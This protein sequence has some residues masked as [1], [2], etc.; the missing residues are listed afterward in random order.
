MEATGSGC[1]CRQSSVP[2][3]TCTGTYDCCYTMGAGTSQTC[4]CGS[5]LTAN[6]CATSIPQIGGTV[7][8]HCRF[9]VGGSSGFE[10]HVDV[11]RGAGAGA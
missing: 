5:T 8:A 6:D 4:T 11:D 9:V 10:R 7:V 3:G 1:V 2:T